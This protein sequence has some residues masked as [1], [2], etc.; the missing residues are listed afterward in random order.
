MFIAVQVLLSTDDVLEVR[1]RTLQWARA[2]RASY[3]HVAELCGLRR[4]QVEDF[5][6]GKTSSIE[7]VAALTNHLPLRVIYIPPRVLPR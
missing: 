6:A 5:L 2:S 4:H 3:R 7:V 1:S